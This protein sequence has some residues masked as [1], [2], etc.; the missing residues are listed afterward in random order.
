MEALDT[1]VEPPLEGRSLLALGQQQNAESH[2][3]E[4]DGVD[5]DVLF[6]GAKPLDH[7]GIRCRLGRLAQDVGVD[8]VLHSASVE[9]ESTGTKNPFAGQA[10]SQSRAPSLG[11]AARRT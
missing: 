5:R 2:L 8:Q 9:S 3:A 1:V 10:S 11:R 4:D 7:P 6:V